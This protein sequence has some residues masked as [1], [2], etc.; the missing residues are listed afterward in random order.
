MN[1]DT[2]L[3]AVHGYLCADGYVIKNPPSQKHKYYHI[4]L[5]NTNKIL[6]KDF[7]RRFT[8]VFKIKPIIIP[9]ERCKIQSKEIFE[10][11]TKNYSYYSYE[12]KLPK[13]NKEQ[14]KFWLRAFF[15]CEAWIEN[16]K[17]KNRA[18]RADCVN[19]NG[20]RDVQKALDEFEI[21]STIRKRK[22]NMWRLNICGL[23]DI[24]NFDNEIGFLHPD[25]K[26]RLAAAIGS[27]KNY[28]WNIP[29]TRNELIQFINLQG[30]KRASRNEIRLFSIRKRNLIVLRNKLSA[31]HISSKLRGPWKNNSG[32]IYF[33]LLLKL[34]DIRELE[35]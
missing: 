31:Y 12:W 28:E 4:G 13:L 3:A 11:L 9:N 33:C 26:T 32:S 6:L 20:L 19:L 18:I 7:Q 21:D 29:K 5:R 1:F 8:K 14:L 10:K 15:D 30:K 25:K 35:E 16:Q 2:N 34:D 22:E 24:R 23:D 27:Y 17:A